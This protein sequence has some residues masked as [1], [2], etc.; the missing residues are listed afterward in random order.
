MGMESFRVDFIFRST[1][2]KEIVDCLKTGFHMEN[3]YFLTRKIFVHKKVLIANEY[4]IENYITVYFNDAET[5]FSL[6]ACFSNFEKYITLIYR[7]YSFLKG[8]FDIG[9]KFNNEI[10]EE[11][12][13]Y[14]SFQ[15]L[16]KDFYSEKYQSFTEKYG[17][18]NT[19]MHTGE[20][21]YENIKKAKR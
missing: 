20:Y 3:G 18:K 10:C 15:L 4:R 7:I 16:I 12:M 17:I 8:N 11:S 13:E 19:D 6:E 21:F 2:Q 1:T 14:S 5:Y 9:I